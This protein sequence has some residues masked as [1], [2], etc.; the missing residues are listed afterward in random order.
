MQS[1][2]NQEINASF[3]PTVS[4]NPSANAGIRELDTAEMQLVGGGGPKGS[5]LLTQMETDFT[6]KK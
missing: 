1:V 6:S 4:A 2:K 3:N 5:V